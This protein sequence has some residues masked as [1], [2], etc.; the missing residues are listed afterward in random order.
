EMHPTA[1]LGLHVVHPLFGVVPVGGEVDLDPADSFSNVDQTFDPGVAD[2][3]GPGTLILTNWRVDGKLTIDFEKIEIKIPPMTDGG[4]IPTGGCKDVGSFSTNAAPLLMA[5][6]TSCHGGG[7]PMAVGAV[8]MSALGA[9]PAA[10]CAQV[11]NR[12]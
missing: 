9:D 6:C 12:V 3:L 4:G 5:N 7:N 11:K 2:L 10:T 8:D 1:K